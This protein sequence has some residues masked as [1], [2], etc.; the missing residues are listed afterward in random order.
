[1]SS[2]NSMLVVIVAKWHISKRNGIELTYMKCRLNEQIDALI[3]VHR[4]KMW[5]ENLAGNIY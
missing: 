4:P 3:I 2:T 1:M 5:N